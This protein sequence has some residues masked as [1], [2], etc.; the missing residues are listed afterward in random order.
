MHPLEE[1]LVD[2]CG[3]AETMF[4]ELKKG[5]RLKLRDPDRPARQNSADAL[6]V[7]RRRM[8]AAEGE[9]ALI[10]SQLIGPGIQEICN[11]T[12]GTGRRLRPEF[13]ADA[14]GW[15]PEQ[16]TE[17]VLA[18]K[19]L[20]RQDMYSKRRWIDQEGDQ[21]LPEMQR[22]VLAQTIAIGETYTAAFWFND[23]IRPFRTSLGILHNDRVRDPMNLSPDDRKEVVAGHRKGPSG[24]TRSYFVHAYHRNDPR[25]DGENFTEVRRFNELGREQII[26]TYVKKLPGLTRGIS[27]LTPAFEKLRCFEKY[28]KVRMEAAIMQVALAFIVKSNDKNLLGQIGGMEVTDDKIKKMWAMAMKRAA[29]SQ[30]YINDTSMNFDG[31]KAIRLLPD[32]DAEILTANQATMNDKQYVDE[33]L[34]SIARS[35]GGLSRATLT[36]D[37]EASFSAARATLISFYRQCENMGQFIVDDWTQSVYSIWLEDVIE[38][39]RLAIPNFPNATNAWMHFVLNR[40]LYCAASFQGPARD[41]IDQAKAMAYWRERKNLGAFSLQEFYDARGKEWRDEI[42]QQF[43]EMKYLDALIDNCKLKHIDPIAHMTGNLE[44]VIVE[45]PSQPVESAQ[46]GAGLD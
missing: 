1:C 20:W 25:S 34:S 3:S 12:V 46:A 21:T 23:P 42:D 16:F 9:D 37:F 14:L 5:A 10:N 6:N 43:E 40:E 4:G 11:A 8:L 41:E 38:S 30:K 29:D 32:E 18:A 35:T 45:A 2:P 27:D 24:R 13:N 33:C 39:G 31:A 15:T 28:Q 17:T 26:H 44:A 19:S 22:M 36:Q 7:P